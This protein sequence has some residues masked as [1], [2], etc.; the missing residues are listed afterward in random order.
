MSDLPVYIYN[1]EFAAPLARVWKTWSDPELLAIW[2]GPGVETIIHSYDLRPGG[3]W[4]NEM[5]WGETSD[6]SRMDFTEVIPQER[7]VWNHASTD[8][9]WNVA[10]NQMMPDWPKTLLTTVTFKAQGDGCKVQLQQVPMDAS[11]A[12]IACFAEMM[13]NMDKG[14]GS[15]FD[16]IEK[17][18]ASHT[19]G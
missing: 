7:I 8:A 19:A 12:E 9:D 3:T 15:G 13:G 5:K 16:L 17:L 1:R 11:D 6:Y 4:L 2:Y 18:L 14:W 10:P